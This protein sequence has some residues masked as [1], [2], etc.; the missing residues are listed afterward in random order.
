MTLGLGHTEPPTDP[1][2]EREPYGADEWWDDHEGEV[3]DA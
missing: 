1:P 3:M 2:E